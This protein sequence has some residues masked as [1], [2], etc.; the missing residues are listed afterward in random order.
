MIPTQC[1][2]GQDPRMCAYCAHKDTCTNR[3]DL[4]KCDIIWGEISG[5]LADQTDLAAEIAS[6]R[7]EIVK[8]NSFSQVRLNI[9]DDNLYVIAP[10]G[11]LNADTDKPVFA[12]YTKSS[13]RKYI[14]GTFYHFKRR[15]WIRPTVQVGNKK[16]Y[17]CVPMIME[18]VTRWDSDV[19][20]YFLVKSGASDWEN[21]SRTY[22]DKVAR[23]FYSARNNYG[24]LNI[25]FVN[26]KLG[27][28]IER[29][30]V[31]I[32]DYLHFSVRNGDYRQDTQWVD[33]YILSRWNTGGIIIYKGV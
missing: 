25:N 12:R 11:L 15:G 33:T 3:C 32:T 10:V 6:V 5:D 4:A 21:P 24:G 30:G 29:N 8:A 26:K 27:L 22:A 2:S 23:D 9:I 19:Y 13:V 17:P 18:K 1:P 28:C 14:D 16:K 7:S 31:Q 20:D